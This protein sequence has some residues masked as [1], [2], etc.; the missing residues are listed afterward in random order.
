[1]TTDQRQRV[2]EV[3]EKALTY[4]PAEQEAFLSA[5]CKD[6]REVRAQVES[7]LA[8][9]DQAPTGFMKLPANEAGSRTDPLI[10]GHIGRY[11]IKGVIAA[12]GMGTVYEAIQEQPSRTVALKVMNRHMTSKSVQRR[13]QFESQILGRLRHAN[14]AQ[15]F[16]SGMHEIDGDKVPYFAMEYIPEAKS[17]TEYA[18]ENKLGIRER[19]QLF[20]TVC[21]AVH[22]GHQKGVIHR[23]L[24]PGNILVDGTGTPKIIDFGVARSVNSDLAMTTQQT[25]V[26]QLVGTLQYMSPEQ[27]QGDVLELDTRSDVYALGV[28][29]YELLCE[30]TPYH[31][32]GTSIQAVLQ[33]ICEKTPTTPSSVNRSLRGNLDLILLKALEKNRD[34]RYQ[35]ASEL[36]QDVRRHLNREPLL[37]R[38]P[39]AW[40]RLHH[41]TLRHPIAVT[42]IACVIIAVVT[43]IATQATVWYVHWQ[44]HAI[45]LASDHQE[46]YLYARNDHVLHAWKSNGPNIASA[47]L[48][49]SMSPLAILGYSPKHT[50]PRQGSFCLFDLSED[51]DTPLWTQRVQTTDLFSRQREQGFVGRDFGAVFCRQYDIFPEHPGI[52]ILLHYSHGLFSARLIHIYDLSGKLL[53]QLWYDGDLYDVYW[54]ADAHI[55]VFLGTNADAYWNERGYKVDAYYPRVLFAVKPQLG[56]MASGYLGVD[57]GAGVPKALWYQCLLPPQESA[58][59]GPF[60]LHAPPGAFE[61]GRFLT[62]GFDLQIEP[63]LYTSLHWVIDEFGNMVSGP[64]V[65]DAYKKHRA[66]LPDPAIFKFGE[67]PPIKISAEE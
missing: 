52:E 9:D 56:F 12:G 35:S 37:A 42:A 13:F 48:I 67:L 40:T 36:A 46:A 10:G 18:T 55:L 21:D 26:G 31:A 2:R 22:H 47:D 58:L 14:I 61:A 5:A 17:I 34:N 3:L 54:M 63:G 4:P 51:Y 1:M 28:I 38:P 19:L 32:V 66:Q 29:L 65:P 25:E 60:R 49:E 6:D 59:A 16:E 45:E 30:M 41:W 53:Y 57:T 62:F 7:L 11:H 43:M 24:K 44:P 64:V 39:T 27:C 15:I 23:D 50:G 8:H 20:A 33:I